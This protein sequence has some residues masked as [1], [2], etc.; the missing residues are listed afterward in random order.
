MARQQDL[1]ARRPLRRT[2]AASLRLLGALVEQC[3]FAQ[4]EFPFNSASRH[5]RQH[6]AAKAFVDLPTLGIDQQKFYFIMQ[7]AELSVT[8][9]TIAAMLDVFEPV[10][11]ANP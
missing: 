1:G 8:V 3:C 6:A 11:L 4:I 9:V 10:V 5:V 7:V 2:I